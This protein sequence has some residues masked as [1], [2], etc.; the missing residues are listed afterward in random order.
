M[1]VVP[2]DSE[3]AEVDVSLS[4]KTDGEHHVIVPRTVCFAGDVQKYPVYDW[5][6]TF[7]LTELIIKV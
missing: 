2:E 4:Y 3:G 1:N 7:K 6:T 5:K